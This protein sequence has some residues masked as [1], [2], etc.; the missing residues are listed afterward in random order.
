[1]WS[2]FLGAGGI[3]WE[4]RPWLMFLTGCSQQG[5]ILWVSEQI[6]VMQHVNTIHLDLQINLQIHFDL[7]IHF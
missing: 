7:Q 3:A 2:V 1:M 4:R 5:E 6:H